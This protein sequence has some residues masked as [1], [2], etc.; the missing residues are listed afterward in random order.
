[1]AAHSLMTSSVFDWSSAL[2]FTSAGMAP[3][4]SSCS[5]AHRSDIS[6]RCNQE[7]SSEKRVANQVVQ[8]LGAVLVAALRE[9]VG[10]VEH[11]SVPGLEEVVAVG[12]VR[13]AAP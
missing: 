8:A 1:M 3:Q 5:P 10:G 6:E 9:L 12:P 7:I 11:L 13:V 4:L 2:A